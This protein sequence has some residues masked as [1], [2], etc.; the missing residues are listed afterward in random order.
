MGLPTER[1]FVVE[2]AAG[3]H[4]VERKVLSWTECQVVSKKPHYATRLSGSVSTTKRGVPRKS[5]LPVVG[6]VSAQY[7]YANAS[8]IVREGLKSPLRPSKE[9]GRRFV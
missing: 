9:S 2:H 1:R 7:D 3:A 5:N 8:R 6:L 4:N